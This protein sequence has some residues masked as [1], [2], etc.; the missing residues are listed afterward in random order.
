MIGRHFS[1]ASSFLPSPPLWSFIFIPLEFISFTLFRA[2][3]SSLVFLVFLFF[4]RHVVM[5]KRNK[6]IVKK[7]GAGEI[8][9]EWRK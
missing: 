6:S 3:S 5:K 7:E 9:D 2:F 8:D 4:G 1:F